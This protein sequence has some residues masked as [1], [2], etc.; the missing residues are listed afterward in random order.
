MEEVMEEVM[1]VNDTGTSGYVP[2]T[3]T[4]H[5]PQ[6]VPAHIS[7]CPHCG[8]CPTC[9]RSNPVRWPSYPPGYPVVW[10]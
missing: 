8:Y 5:V 2:I 6:P 7:N 9:G 3:T 10:Y 4:A 1:Y